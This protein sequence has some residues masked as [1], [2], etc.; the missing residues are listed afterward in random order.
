MKRIAYASIAVFLL[1]CSY[2]S[3]SADPP[4]RPQGVA[5]RDW[6]PVSDRL[7]IVLVD[8]SPPMDT[9]AEIPEVGIDRRR[10][11]RSSPMVRGQER[12]GLAAPVGQALLL[13]PPLGGY[14]MVK[15]ASGWT[16]LV[17]VEPAKGPGDAG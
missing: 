6:V 4:D 5:D 1:A 8:A 16:R 10:V 2:T 12:P 17:V 14:F 7:G 11:D 9:T 13:K 15:G 3:L